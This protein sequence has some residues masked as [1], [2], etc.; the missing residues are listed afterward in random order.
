MK[1]VFL[2]FAMLL[3]QMNAQTAPPADSTG[4][5]EAQYAGGQEQMDVFITRN[6][7]YPQ[8]AF[9]RHIEGT[10][11][12]RI[13]LT[14]EGTVLH[15]AVQRGIDSG[16][17]EEALRLVYAMPNWIPAMEGDRPV[18]SET[19]IRIDFRIHKQQPQKKMKTFCRSH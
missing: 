17:D 7:Q 3:S 9:N 11:T 5:R 18:A 16:C 10:V 4:S 15:A 14:A 2:L 13:S 6:L 1:T 19:T 8:Y 12:I